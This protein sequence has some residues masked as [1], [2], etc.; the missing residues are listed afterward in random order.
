M[1]V[2]PIATAV[3]PPLSKLMKVD[4][5][6]NADG[7][8]LVHDKPFSELI[9]WMEYDAELEAV[10]L[11][12]VNGQCHDLGLTVP[13]DIGRHL[14]TASEVNIMYMQNGQLA[15]LALVPIVTRTGGR[16]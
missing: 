14:E 8:W 15:D 13:Y 16:G 7:V 5:L 4:F 2:D 10:T 9:D 3:L 1:N 6:F 12:T 11:V